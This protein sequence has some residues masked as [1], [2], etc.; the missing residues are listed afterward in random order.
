M[1]ANRQQNFSY[2]ENG[3][4]M[5][6]GSQLQG[7]LKNSSWN[8]VTDLATYQEGDTAPQLA[9]QDIH[10]QE[11]VYLTWRWVT[12]DLE[13]K[14]QGGNPR[15]AECPQEP[16]QVH[17]TAVSCVVTVTLS[18]VDKQGPKS[19]LG[20]QSQPMPYSWTACEWKLFFKHCKKIAKK[21]M[22]QRPHGCKA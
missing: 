12:C 1:W 8:K 16:A 10:R 6:H 19:G 7:K 13:E 2:L 4:I 17:G 22:S 20:G 9:G 5:P 21:S 11:V 18:P 15:Q 14:C 3:S